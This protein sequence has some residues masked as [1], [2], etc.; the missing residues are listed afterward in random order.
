MIRAAEAADAPAIAAIWN[1]IIRETAVTF[2]SVEKSIPSLIAL[3]E[4]K[5]ALG[6]PFL[7]AEEAGRILGFATYGAFRGG[8]GY[9]RIAEHTILLVP[10]AQGRGAGRRLMAALEEKAL[11]Q[12][13]ASLMAGVSGENPGGIGFH[14]AI[15][16][17]EVGR[18]P[19]A[20]WKFERW[21]DLVLMQKRLAAD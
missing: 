6:H 18:I 2:N 12:G 10:E 5:A 17:V 4:E 15:G 3:L 13:I 19:Q 20:G 21:M 11:A 1:P 16:F 14:R 8:V 7:L 9:R